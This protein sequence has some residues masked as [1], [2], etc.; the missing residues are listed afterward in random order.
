MFKRFFGQEI[1]INTVPIGLDEFY[2]WCEEV[3]ALTR[4]PHNDSMR[5]ALA[6]IVLES[7]EILTREHAAQRLVKAAQNQLAAFVFNDIKAK[8]MAEDALKETEKDATVV[9][10][11]KQS[12]VAPDG[13]S[14]ASA[15]EMVP[16]A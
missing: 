6:S 13:G 15:S 2:R 16:A 9:N 5:F 14:Q 1:D 7:K 8:R 4:L 10:A 12:G 3:L 11:D